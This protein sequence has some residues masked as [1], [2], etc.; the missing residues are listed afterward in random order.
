MTEKEIFKHYAEFATS[1]ATKYGQLLK[2][3]E[4][5]KE[6]KKTTEEKVEL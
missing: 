6:P 5:P 2:P 4:D 3:D 1:R